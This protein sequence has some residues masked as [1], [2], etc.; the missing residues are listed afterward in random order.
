M[1]GDA[2]GLDRTTTAAFER[3]IRARTDGKPSRRY[4]EQGR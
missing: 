4:Q 1:L 2:L 3:C